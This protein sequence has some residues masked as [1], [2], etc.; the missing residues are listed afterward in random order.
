MMRGV[1]EAGDVDDE[2]DGLLP[3]NTPTFELTRKDE[4]RD[5]KMKLT[6]KTE[7]RWTSQAQVYGLKRI[8]PTW[9]I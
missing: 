3:S 4:N 7:S 1:G 5:S 2:V 9:R 8:H 6:G